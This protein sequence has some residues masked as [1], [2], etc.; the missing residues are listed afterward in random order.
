MSDTV[1]RKYDSVVLGIDAGG[2]YFKS[3]LV[4]IEGKILKDSYRQTPVSSYGTKAEIMMTYK[5][6]IQAASE[7][8]CA[9]S[10]DIC[11]IGISTPG[12]FDYI[13]GISSMRHDSG[14]RGC[15]YPG[16]V[17]AMGLFQNDLPVIF[18]HDA[19]LYL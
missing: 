9:D 16:F 4:N 2:T 6:I 17:C 19:M 18:M 1:K 14:Y 13:G 12:P 10:I 3:A 7:Y 5:K 11:G 15:K 8:T